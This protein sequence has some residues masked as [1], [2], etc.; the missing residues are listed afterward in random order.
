[1]TDTPTSLP[2]EVITPSEEEAARLE[3]EAG[4]LVVALPRD[5]K[6]GYLLVVRQATMAEAEITAA[7]RAHAQ[8]WTTF[9]IFKLAR[10]VDASVS[11]SPSNQG[12]PHD[13]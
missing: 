2:L 3:A 10:L 7:T 4:Y 11:S 13:R 6:G 1:M 5:G 8:P 12:A 9:G